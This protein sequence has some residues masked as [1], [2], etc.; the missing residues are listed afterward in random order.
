MIESV[1]YDDVILAADWNTDFNRKTAQTKY[2]VQQFMPFLKLKCSWNHNN[3]VKKDTFYSFNGNGSSC[4]DYFLMSERLFDDIVL[5]I[6]VWQGINL[7][8]HQPV[9]LTLNSKCADRCV[10]MD[11]MAESGNKHA[12]CRAT[13]E[14]I[15]QYQCNINR[16]LENIKI[17]E[18]VINCFDNNCSDESHLKS[19]DN[20]CE[21]ILKSC[22]LASDECIP[23]VKLKKGIPKWNEVARPAKETALF[24]HSIWLSCGR[25]NTGFVCNIR[26]TTRATYHRLV[27]DLKRNEMVNRSEKMAQSILS[28]NNR[29][30]WR[31]NKKFKRSKKII[32]NT[33]DGVQGNQD[34]A[35]YFASKYDTLYNSVPY[36]HNKMDTIRTE[37]ASRINDEENVYVNITPNDVKIAIG[38]LKGGK[39]DGDAGLDSDHLIYGT[40]KLYSILCI[41]I[42]CSFRHS[43][44]AECLKVSTIV[45]IPKDY[46]SSLINSDNYRGIC[47]CSS[48]SKLFDIIMFKNNGDKLN[49]SDLQFAYKKRMSTTMCTTIAKEVVQHYKENGTDVHVCLLDASKAFDKICFDKLFQR[50]LDRRFPARYINL[51]INSYLDQVIRVKWGSSVSSNFKGVNGIRQGG[52]IS[53]IL[54]TVYIDSLISDLKSSKAGCWI[55]H[56]YYGCLVFADDIKLLSPSATGLQRMVDVCANFGDENSITFNEK[57]SVCMRF[58]VNNHNPDILLNGKVLK[59]ENRVKHIGNVLNPALDDSDDIQLKQQE[60]FQQVNRLLVDYQGVRWDILAHLFKRYCGS[61]YG[62]QSWDLRSTHIQGLYRSWNRAVRT[63]LKLPYDSHR[64]LLPLLLK[65]PSLEVQ[66]M[67]RF[68]KMC[69]TMYTSVN[70]SV[71]FLIRYCLENS[72]SKIGKNLFYI[73]SIN[74]CTVFNMLNNWSTLIKMNTSQEQIRTSEFVKELLNIRDGV[75]NFGHLQTDQVSEIINYVTAN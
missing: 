38:C 27:K 74:R 9:L 67:R 34:I 19:L 21:D 24:W 71:S 60:F 16:K 69:S 29:D 44:M 26:R 57:K 47:L 61:F 12:W 66:L 18:N 15:R 43:Y 56:H 32:P 62:S 23:C 41:L 64:Y 3:S 33:M 13:E 28:N 8:P 53:P 55:G 75:I 46:R 2:L 68:V 50:L 25:P 49:T 6:V 70:E 5:S 35:S 72:S 48:I 17:S 36:D 7:S 65:M 14:H 20:L 40:E 30:F 10:V 52:V 11:E 42:N 73:S 51:L 22:F 45:S 37:L 54:F 58:G 59:W 39:S 63:M 31:E 1:L 4:I